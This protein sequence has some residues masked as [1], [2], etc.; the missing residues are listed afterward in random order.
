MAL[1]GK[2]KGKLSKHVYPI[3]RGLRADVTLQNYPQLASTYS[4]LKKNVENGHF[5]SNPFRLCSLLLSVFELTEFKFKKIINRENVFF[6]SFSFVCNLI[7]IQVSFSTAEVDGV[8]LET[9][10]D[11][12]STNPP[13]KSLSLSSST[14]YLSRRS[15][16]LTNNWAITQI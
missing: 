4:H 16:N 10:T 1:K 7:L 9:L 3:I 14:Q 11:G 8:L 2:Y 12:V 15:P 13:K 5:N 6:S